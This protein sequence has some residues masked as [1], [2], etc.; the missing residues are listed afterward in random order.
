MYV[1]PKNINAVMMKDRRTY[2]VAVYST[3]V[4]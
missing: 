1:C 4:F 3:L 2:S